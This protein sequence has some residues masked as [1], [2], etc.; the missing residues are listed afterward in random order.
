MG[1]ASE[2]YAKDLK[3]DYEGCF[4]F[5][6]QPSST[7]NSDFTIPYV[8]WISG[9]QLILSGHSFGDQ[10]WFQ[11]VANIQHPVYDLLTDQII[12]EFGEGWY[13]QPDTQSQPILIPD[14]FMSKLNPKDPA[15]VADTLRI[16][17]KYK[18]TGVT[19]VRCLANVIFDK[20]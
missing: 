14:N 1:V 6:I 8:K 13:V 12:N 16:R 10:V 15:I 17:I 20:Q 9:I 18:N 3:S 5:L 4:D 2:K 11:I 19:E 7:V